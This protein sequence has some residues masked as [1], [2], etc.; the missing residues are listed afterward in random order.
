MA[1]PAPLDAPPPRF[2]PPR[3]VA[4]GVA[5]LALWWC[6]TR[7]DAETLATMRSWL[8]PGEHA[9]AARFGRPS[10]ADRYVAGRACLR[11]VLG[12]MLGLA[13]HAVPIERGPRGRPRLASAAA[14]L[15]FNVSNTRDVALI[16]VVASAAL[17][18][19]VD[20]EHG[21]RAVDDHGLARKFCTEAERRALA[22]LEGD[23]RRRRFLRLWTCKEAMSKATGDALSAPLRRLDV[24]VEPSL[25]LAAGPPPYQ[26]PAWRLVDAP[27]PDDYVATV[28][29][30]RVP[31]A[32]A[33][34]LTR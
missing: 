22:A 3:E 10:L 7:A 34:G 23:A 28:A 26:P 15:D 17:R 25:R 19:G 16:G 29:L 30:W 2:V 31:V 8:S 20:V 1:M 5:G 18:V 21:A 11:L 4:A 9:R 24:A 32:A 33:E 27:V 14:G 6:S 13:P 12:T